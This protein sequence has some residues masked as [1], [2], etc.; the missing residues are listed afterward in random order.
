MIGKN[1]SQIEPG[2]DSNFITFEQ[3]SII[4]NSQRLWMQLA[5]WIRD[6]SYTVF[7]DSERK[8][9]TFNRLYQGVTMDFYNMISIF[10]GNEIAQQFL[11]LFSNFILNLWHVMESLNENNQKAINTNTV[12][13]YQS[14]N[15]FAQFFSRINLY[16]DEAQWKSLLYQYI[17]MKIDNALAIAAKDFER[18]VVVFDRIQNLAILMG[19]YMARGIIAR[20]LP[21]NDEE[22]ANQVASGS[23]DYFTYIFGSLC[24]KEQTIS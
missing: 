21:W 17:R 14:A 9:I 24:P 12:Q 16:W 4:A 11:N 22:A 5:I 3:M 23:L 6:L 19:N 7:R 2:A 13:L 10:Y 8:A 20:N 1:R 15:V 18:E